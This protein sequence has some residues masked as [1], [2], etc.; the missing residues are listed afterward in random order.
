MSYVNITD[1]KILKNDQPFLAPFEFEITF[2]CLSELKDDLDFKV[3][4]VSSGTN[5]D[6]DQV[7]E[8]VSVGP[9]PIGINKF[10]LEAPPP[11][12]SAIDASDLL[13]VSVVLLQVSYM[14]SEFMRIGY[15]VNNEYAD[16]ALKAAPPALPVVDRIVK[17]LLADKPRVTRFHI[18]WDD[19]QATY[20]P[21]K[22]LD[23][24]GE[25]I[26]MPDSPE[27]GMD[28]D[29]APPAPVSAGF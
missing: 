28:Q 11:N 22:L 21:R 2:E 4:Y 12:P 25:Y 6:K 17:N 7:L 18:N 16:P 9:I 29:A 14:S 10:V 23:D 1:V 15:L 5:E 27:D 24:D 8:S 26:D 20:Y 19:P 13:G 3:V